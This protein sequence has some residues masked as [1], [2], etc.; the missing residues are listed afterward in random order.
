MN[1]WTDALQAKSRID[2][3]PND[4]EAWANLAFAQATL[5]NY[6]S[7]VKSYARALYFYPDDANMAHN[8]GHVLDVGLNQ[9]DDGIQWFEHALRIEPANA[10]FAVSYGHALGR[11]KRIGDAE[12]ALSCAGDGQ[13]AVKMRRWLAA[14]APSALSR[15]SRAQRGPST[16]R[17]PWRP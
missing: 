9:P 17:A 5:G 14:G 1:P 15:Q 16:A 7:A 2:K 10:D 3:N 11:C 6:H 12:R 4:A 13:E 8:L